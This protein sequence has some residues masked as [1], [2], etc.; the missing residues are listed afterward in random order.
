MGSLE[1]FAEEF[2]W[3][4]EVLQLVS[5][6]RLTANS[7]NSSVCPKGGEN[8]HLEVARFGVL[9]FLWMFYSPEI[10]IIF[11]YMYTH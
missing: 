9:N 5:F 10:L 1:L 11:H 3:S 2:L 4:F 7:S 6:G 8:Q